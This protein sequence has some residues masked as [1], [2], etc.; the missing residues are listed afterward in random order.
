MAC[1]ILWYLVGFQGTPQHL[2]SG[3]VFNL[4]IWKIKIKVTS[5]WNTPLGR[6]SKVLFTN[7]KKGSCTLWNQ[8]FSSWH[9]QSQFGCHST[10]LGYPVCK[11]NFKIPADAKLVFVARCSHSVFH[12]QVQDSHSQ[13]TPYKFPSIYLFSSY[14]RSRHLVYHKETSLVK[15]FGPI[16]KSRRTHVS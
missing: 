15:H 14:S 2:P 10:W 12:S 13:L 4:T 5:T 16:A 7:E 3:L 1:R 8:L 11:L 9:N 6:F